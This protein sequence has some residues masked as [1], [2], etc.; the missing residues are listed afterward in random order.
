MPFDPR[1]VYVAGT[2]SRGSSGSDHGNAAYPDLY[3]A[4]GVHSGLARGAAHDIPSAFAAMRQGGQASR[5]RISQQVRGNVVP[6][7]VFHGDQ[8]STVQSAQRRSGHRAVEGQREHGPADHGCSTVGYPAGIPTAARRTPTP[9]GQTVSQGRG[10]CLVGR[11]P[12][13]AP[14]DRSAGPRRGP[15]MLPVSFSSI[16]PKPRGPLSSD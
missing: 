5:E 11:Q 16:Q 10:P 8:D 2:V 9:C 14:D 12:Q 7:I 1:R 13:P 15:E 4:I 3:A 6:T